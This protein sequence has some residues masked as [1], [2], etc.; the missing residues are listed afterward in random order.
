MSVSA[1]RLILGERVKS[2]RKSMGLSQMDLA[3][4]AGTSQ[5]HIS[6]I[7]KEQRGASDKVKVA[8][9]EAL[10]TSLAYLTGE[11]DDPS[12]I[13]ASQGT[14]LQMASDWSSMLRDLAH[15]DPDL[16][17][18]LRDTSK[19]WDNVSDKTK[20]AIVLAL[21]LALGREDNEELRKKH[22]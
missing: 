4:I 22:R 21:N 7:E 15:I 2:L 18:R 5:N 19:D 20:K 9:A 11:T 12:P 14:T 1:E 17:V 8:L 3:A 10:N 16:V 6:A 13:S